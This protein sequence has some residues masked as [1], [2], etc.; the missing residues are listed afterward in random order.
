MKRNSTLQQLFF[1]AVVSALT[2]YALFRV[3]RRSD[4]PVAFSLGLDE[5]AFRLSP[6]DLYDDLFDGE[7]AAG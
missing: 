4:H 1:A 6:E 7:V 3:L 2:P 5:A